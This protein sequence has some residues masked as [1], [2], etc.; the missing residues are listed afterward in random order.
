MYHCC[1]AMMEIV[2]WLCGTHF[3]HVAVVHKNMKMKHTQSGLQRYKLPIS[4]V[5]HALVFFHIKPVRLGFAR[6]ILLFVSCDTRKSDRAFNGYTFV[7]CLIWK[8][9]KGKRKKED[10]Y[11]INKKLKQITHFEPSQVLSN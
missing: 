10:N 9:E 11:W 7:P 4:P 2:I 6:S 5:Q 1:V 8:S 3:P